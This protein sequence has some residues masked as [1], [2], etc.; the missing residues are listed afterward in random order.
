M[1]P[2]TDRL[3]AWRDTALSDPVRA[4]RVAALAAA[5]GLR[6]DWLASYLDTPRACGRELLRAM[7]QW[8]D[9]NPDIGPNGPFAPAHSVAAVD[10]LGG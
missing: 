10:T 2:E 7:A 9:E 5:F 1:P 6:P 8:C 4:Y 3:R